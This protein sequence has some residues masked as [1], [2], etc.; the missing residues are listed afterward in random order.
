MSFVRSFLSGFIAFKLKK[1]TLLLYIPEE[2][3]FCFLRLLTENLPDVSGLDEVW[4]MDWGRES[5]FY[6]R[7]C[8]EYSLQQT[9]ESDVM[10]SRPS[11]FP[12]QKPMTLDPS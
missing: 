6:L 12:V 8:L 1:L 3:L 11:S 2:K 10:A 5:R 4:K 9:T 7:I